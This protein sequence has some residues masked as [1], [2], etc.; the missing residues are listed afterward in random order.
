MPTGLSTILTVQSQ[1]TLHPFRPLVDCTDM[2][3]AVR[4]NQRWCTVEVGF[5]RL[6]HLQFQS[7]VE[8]SLGTRNP[9]HTSDDVAWQGLV[10]ESTRHCAGASNQHGYIVLGLVIDFLGIDGRAVTGAKQRERVANPSPH[11]SV[12]SLADSQFWVEYEY[13]EAGLLCCRNHG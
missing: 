9:R 5:V 12:F 2:V 3:Q 10:H 8:P 6:P 7:V 1:P 11:H 13:N 4:F